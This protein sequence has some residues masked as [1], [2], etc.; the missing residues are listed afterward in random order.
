MCVEGREGGK[1]KKERKKEREREREREREWEW[2]REIKELF[3]YIST[4]CSR[5]CWFRWGS[6]IGSVD[7]NVSRPWGRRVSRVLWQCCFPIYGQWGKL[8]LQH[9]T[10]HTYYIALLL[11][12]AKLARDLKKQLNI[13]FDS[14]THVPHTSATGKG[15]PSSTASATT[16]AAAS[17]LRTVTSAREGRLDSSGQ[18]M[19]LLCT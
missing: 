19:W 16:A 12:I 3:C 11:Q 2:V 17:G 6:S 4:Q 13:G 9:I 18:C 15:E 10:C 14:P 8:L 7:W 1:G 5:I